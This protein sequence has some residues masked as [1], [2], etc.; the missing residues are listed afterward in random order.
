MCERC[1]YSV[2]EGFVNPLCQKDTPAWEDL[3]TIKLFKYRTNP[4]LPDHTRIYPFRSFT[5]YFLKDL[6]DSANSSA[7]YRYIISDEKTGE[8]VLLLWILNWNCGLGTFHKQDETTMN[9]NLVSALKVLYKF[10]CRDPS[11]LEEQLILKWSNDRQVEH[12]QYP[13]DCLI[14]LKLALKNATSLLPIEK[15]KVAEFDS[16]IIACERQ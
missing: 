13:S 3:D 15:R 9:C 1:R 14:E 4:L 6:I 8:P 7:F 12:L 5:H 11:K 16:A 2:G 10:F